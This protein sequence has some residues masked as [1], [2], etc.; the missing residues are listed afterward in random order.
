MAQVEPMSDKQLKYIKD[1]VN[2]KNINNA[3]HLTPTE[4]DYLN[5]GDLT[6]MNKSEASNCIAALLKCSAQAR[7]TGPQPA[8]T[9]PTNPTVEYDTTTGY[10]GVSHVAADLWP[11][12]HAGYY[13]IV[14]PSTNT[15]SFFRVDKPTEGKWAGCIFLHIQASD[16][17]YPVRGEHRKDA[18]LSTI[19]E[20]PITAM[21]QY[22]MRLGRCGRCNRTLTK[23]DSRLR[24]L[25][26]ICAQYLDSSAS[27][28]DLEL[29]A[30]LGLT[31][32]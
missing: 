31:D 13:F 15:E 2:K 29:L 32:D 19:N 7:V 8:P 24:G 1:L 17:F 18:I 30:S 20:D 10:P 11:N 21:N 3:E 9:N 6:L 5:H 12:I 16:D 27:L 14:D 22:G 26:P 4:K 28:E 23:R 25:G